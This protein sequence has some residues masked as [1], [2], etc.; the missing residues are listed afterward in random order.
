MSEER[1][2]VFGWGERVEMSVSRRDRRRS[3]LVWD[4]SGMGWQRLGWSR[5]GVC[6]IW[7]IDLCIYRANTHTSRMFV[8]ITFLSPPV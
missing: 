4:M 1:G 2:A 5:F 8:Q 3:N 7:D 6:V